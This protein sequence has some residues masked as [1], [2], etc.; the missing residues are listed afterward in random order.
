MRHLSQQIANAIHIMQ[1]GRDPLVRALATIKHGPYKVLIEAFDYLQIF[2]KGFE[3]MTTPDIEVRRRMPE[4]AKVRVKHILVKDRG[5][6][7]SDTPMR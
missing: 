7:H 6:K 5:R 3:S 1:T 4:G 2:A